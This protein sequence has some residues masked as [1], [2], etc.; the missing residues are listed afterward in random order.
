M[1]IGESYYKMDKKTRNEIEKQYQKNILRIYNKHHIQPSIIVEYLYMKQDNEDEALE[2]LTQEIQR[3]LL[4]NH[5]LAY[6]DYSSTVNETV[7][8]IL[9]ELLR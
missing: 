6:T 8:H 7:H 5:T 3:S 2:M 4:Y 1:G 9:N